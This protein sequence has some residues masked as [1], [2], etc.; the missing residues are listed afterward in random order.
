MAQ[1]DP[2][3]QAPGA[4]NLLKEPRETV[5]LESW[6]TLS[7]QALVEQS[8]VVLWIHETTAILLIKFSCWA[9]CYNLIL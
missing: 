1:P 6:F 4:K 3:E 7:T 8:I 5:A 9:G 2:L